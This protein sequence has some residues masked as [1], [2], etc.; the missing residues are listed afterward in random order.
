MTIPTK[1]TKPTVPPAPQR[2]E[3]PVNFSNK[4]NTFVLFYSTLAD[5]TDAS[6][7]WQQTVYTATGQVYGDTV[8]AANAAASSASSA[9]S[10]ASSASAS[11]TA[12]DD[13]EAQA[14]IYAAAAQ[15]AAGAP[16]IV[17]KNQLPLVVKEDGSGVEWGGVTES[18]TDATDGKLLKVGDFGIGVA[19]DYT[20]SLD[21]IDVTSF[22]TIFGITST[23]GPD[24]F[25]GS[26]AVATVTTI[27]RDADYASQLFVGARGTFSNKVY[28]RIRDAGVWQDWD[29]IYH[30]SNVVGTVSQ[31]GGVPTGAII[32]R[33]S[34]VNGEYAKFADGT[35][36]CT[37]EIANTSAA[38]GT[39]LQGGYRSDIYNWTF[40]TA[41]ISRPTV[42]SGILDLAFGGVAEGQSPTYSRYIYT[43]VT[44]QPASDRTIQL[45]AIGRWY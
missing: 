43:A 19:A 3:S 2:G 22:R 40:P 32:E 16:S 9:A 5:Y 11:A 7:D 42:S 4:V 39:A 6:L 29:E 35:L 24:T 26:S 18:P 1:P 8:I 14:Q 31:S 33:G 15:A 13:S 10:S 37:S 28:V 23:G 25:D 30:Q 44:A 20:G 17:G 21:N 38:I 34:N 41:F 45:V 36:I 12:A 27:Y